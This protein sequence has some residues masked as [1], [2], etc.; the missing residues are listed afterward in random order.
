MRRVTPEATAAEAESQ[1][2]ANHHAAP[3]HTVLGL[4]GSAGNQAVAR[5]F[6]ARE[7]D[8]PDHPPV[9][10]AAPDREVTLDWVPEVDEHDPAVVIAAQGATRE[11]LAQ[12]LYGDPNR[13]GGFDMV[14]GRKARLRN[15]DGVVPEVATAVR[16]AFDRRLPT[17]ANKVVGILK[18]RLIGDDDE[19][20]LLNTTEWWASRGDLTNSASRSY[21]DAYLDELDTHRLEEWGLFSNTVKPA[22]EW[23]VVEAEEKKWAILPLIARRTSRTGTG[24]SRVTGPITAAA[25]PDNEMH[26]TVGTYTYFAGENRTL[27]SSETHSQGPIT[28][29]ELLVTETAANRAEIALRNTQHGRARVMIPGGD[30]KFYGYTIAYPDFWNEGY[31]QPKDSDKPRLERFWWHYPGTVFIPGGGF[32]PEVAQGGAP[33]Q[34]QR[35]EILASALA[36]GLEALRSLDFDVLSALNLDQRVTV[37]GLTVAGQPTGADYSLIARVLY[38][39]PDAEF[40]VLEHRLSTNGT[41][42]KLFNR[43]DPGLAMIGRVFTVK[44][45]AAGQVPGEGLQDVPDIKVGF[46]E[47]GYY[48]FAFATPAK[49]NSQL[50]PAGQAPAGGTVAIGQ[51]RAGPGETPG[52]INRSVWNLQPEVFR[53]GGYAGNFYRGIT[54]TMVVDDGPKLGPY[55]PSQLVKVTSAGPA[56]ETHVVSVLE[57]IGLLQLPSAEIL[58]QMI[59]TTIRG[60]MWMLAGMSLAKAF[61]PALAEGLTG[62]TGVAAGVAEAAATQAGRAAIVNAALLGGMEIVDSHRAELQATAEGRAFLQVYDATMMIWIAHDVGRL[63]MSGLLPRLATAA[64]AIVNLPGAFREGVLSVRGEVEALLRTIRKYAT[65]AEAAAA[66]TAEGATVAAATADTRQSFSALYRISRGEVAAE[67]LTARIAGT[68]AE[69][70]GKRVLDR[71]SGLV[72]RSEAEATAATGNSAEATEARAAASRRAQSA[73][74]AQF[75]LSSRAAALR[76][77]AREAFLRTVDTIVGTRPNALASMTDLLIA[78]AESRTPNTFLTEVQ[79]LVNRRGVSAEALLVLGRKAREGATTLDLAWLNRT[80]IDDETLDFLGRDRRTQWDL[81]RRTAADQDAGD[82][83]RRFRTSARGVGAEIVAED[84]AAGLGSNVRRQVKM[85]SSEIDYEITVE[86]RRHG[87]EIK[88]WTRETWEEA[89]EAAIKRLNRKGLTE[90][91]RQAV[92][93]IDSMIGQLQDAQAATRRRV[94]LGFTDALPAPQRERLR[95]VLADN[96]LSSTEFVPLAEAEIKDAAA[97]LG[98]Q[99]GIPRP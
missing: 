45:V 23:L 57:A 90:E 39:T 55:L 29:G 65:P 87:F 70:P 46:D 97:T 88:G 24:Y 53:L 14:D 15:L 19:W 85:G 76:P 2:P 99:L 89:L 42:E 49:A 36:G 59:T 6:V 44:S 51:E 3:V 84:V 83:M 35:A 16:T 96:G 56:P 52:A 4:A 38:T 20:Q 62:G 92:R 64:D 9:P 40:P 75:A 82:L 80:S 34:A 43:M 21:F 26:G 93:K 17:D 25:R 27:I 13:Y 8:D 71:L 12:R 11:Q 72:D 1:Q 37:I 33:E 47:E 50:L 74:D 41:M 48:H 61:G 73:A 98:Q 63:I 94:Y 60:G 58:H 28:I 66:A 67:R 32:Q 68:A 22:S 18:E 86:G 81:F 30:G 54:G 78:A 10:A 79:T 77:E 91:Q 5:L 7:V 31:V 69:A 95:R